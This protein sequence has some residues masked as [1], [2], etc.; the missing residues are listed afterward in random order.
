M[1]EHGE[2]EGPAA[3]SVEPIFDADSAALIALTN[4]RFLEAARYHTEQYTSI[5]EAFKFYDHGTTVF[6]G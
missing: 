2:E 5:V 3:G 4:E 1:E 6:G